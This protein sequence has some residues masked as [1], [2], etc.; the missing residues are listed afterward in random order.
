[1][2]RSLKSFPPVFAIPGM[3]AVLV[4]GS[5][6]VGCRGTGMDPDAKSRLADV[7]IQE[8]A[9]F[10]FDTYEFAMQQ[11]DGNYS[12][13]KTSFAK[14]SQKITATVPVGTYKLTLEYVKAKEVVLSSAFCRDGVRKDVHKLV[15]GSNNLELPICNKDAEPVT[16]TVIIKPVP[17]TPGTNPNPNPPVG[18]LDTFSIK[19]GQLIDASGKPFAFRGIN[20]PF[21]YSFDQS[22]A[23][24]DQAKAFG[25][26]SVRMV[27]CADTYPAPGRCDPQFH[28]KSAGDL[29]RALTKIADLRMVAMLNLQNVTGA[30]V[31]VDESGNKVNV[32]PLETM[33]DYLIKDEIKTVLMKHK[34]NLVINIANEW[35]GKWDKNRD[36]VDSYKAVIRRLRAAGIPHSLVIDARG[37]GQDFSAVPEHAVELMAMDKNIIFSAH[38][39]DEFGTSEKVQSALKYVKDNKIP[40]LIGEYS[41]NHPRGGVDKPVACSTI[42][43][44]TAASPVGTIAWSYAGNSSDL[45]GLDLVSVSDWKTLTPFGQTIVNGPNGMKATSKE[46]CMF[47]AIKCP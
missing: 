38:M 2:S 30:G 11:Q 15:A 19:E 22:L 4:L 20:M 40:F 12:I 14:G 42:L 8:L 17:V 29:D 33:A 7:T 1:M 31:D 5:G 23:A 6:A 27:W 41:C 46:A 9:G 28:V 45:V 43:Q 47:N 34:R 25:F 26:N 18:T 13:G 21:A 36:W 44:E 39:Y 35:L 10:D 24:L 37:Y 16:S 3:L 32:K